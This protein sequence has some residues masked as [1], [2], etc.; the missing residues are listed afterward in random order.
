MKHDP[1]EAADGRCV[2]PS[3]EPAIANIIDVRL[4]RRAALQGLGAA[5]MFSLFGCGTMA[6]GPRDSADGSAALAFTELGRTTD[7]Q[8]HVA[9]GHNVQVLIR[10]GDPIQR[11]APQYRP[12]Q[13]TAADQERQFG[14][15]NDFLAF[16]P[17]PR[18]SQSSTRGLLGVNHENHRAVLCFPGLTS[19]NSSQLT[20][21]QC[22]VQMAAQGFSIIEIQKIG[23][24]WRLV[25]DS[26]YNR[27][28]S[29]TAVMRAAGPAA[30]SARL[31][32]NADPSGTRI[33]GTFN[34]C[35][36]GT[37][38]WG[39]ILTAEE[40]IQNYFVGNAAQGSEAAARKR[41]GISG[42]GRYDVWGRHFERFNLDKEPN[43]P[44]RFGWIVEIDPYDPKSIPAKRT[45]LGRC[46]HECATSA[47]SH[48]GRVAIY[49]GDDA[50]MEYVYK[51]VTHGRYD[52]SRPE[53]SRDLLDSGT[54]YA[55][56]FEANGKMRWLPLVYGQEPLNAANN[57]NSQADVVIEARRAADLLGATPMDRPEDVEAHPA[58]GRV[59]VVLTYN[60][61]RKPDQV[62]PANPRA[63]N[64]HGHIIEI[65]P[66]LANGKPDHTA[67][68][69]DWGFF[70]LGGDPADPSHGARYGG[71]VT[72]NGWVAAPDNLAFDPKGRIWIS[73]DGQ[74]DAAGFNDSLYAAEVSG[75]RRGVTRCFFN[76]PRGAEICGP[77]FTPD[78]KTLFLSVQHPGDEK[79][80]S[81]DKPS[82]RWPDFQE[83]MPPRSAV[84]AIT[85]SDGGD[86]GG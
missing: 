26:P 53:A 10:Q 32:T 55:A 1:F 21:A 13:Q 35:A 48:D 44:N 3:S 67:T 60:E 7:D 71:Q 31:R 82:T 84:L 78:G 80:S 79:G 46:A 34:N 59:Y 74:D 37:T 47:V 64:R 23:N 28:L 16:M 12:G 22:E 17:L 5:S 57:F 76:G 11:G 70:L 52:S 54:L 14:T 83:G 25:E 72:A 81:F 43:E 62:N 33:F 61:Q 85:R 56:K 24:S 8:A 68:E 27:R 38:P 73:T 58:S 29:A 41:Y 51:F 86:I 75:S 36:G 9:S 18:G 50:R 39:T 42:R 63:N 66:P 15:D 49:S 40:N 20:R 45:A 6:H 4:S 30:G 19:Q 69:C 2:N 65:V 77:A